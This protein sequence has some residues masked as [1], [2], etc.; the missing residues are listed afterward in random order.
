M[1][2][3]PKDFHFRFPIS[4]KPGHK[5]SAYPST[6]PLTPRWLVSFDMIL[7]QGKTYENYENCLK[8]PNMFLES[9]S[10][11]LIRLEKNHIF[12]EKSH[13]F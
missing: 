7:V 2:S 8:L 9:L 4:R 6:V 13:F 11:D 12:L 5:V 1:S 10:F 3:G